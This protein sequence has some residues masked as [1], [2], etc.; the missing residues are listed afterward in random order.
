MN[1]YKKNSILKSENL[2]IGYILKKRNIEIAKGLNISLKLGKLVCLLGKNGTGK[3]TLLRTIAKIQ[4]PIKG[5]LFIKDKNINQYSNL[6]LAK[7]ISLV[8]TERIPENNLTVFELV[9]LGRQPYTN[10]IGNLNTTD[11]AKINEA[12][13][14]TDIKNL[15]DN[16]FNELSD[17]QKQRVLIARAIAQDTPIIIL[18][19]PTAHLDI[20]HKIATVRLLKTISQ[21]MNKSI[22]MAT[23]EVQL[24]LSLADELWLM[25]NNEFNIGSPDDLITNG[26]L[27]SLFSSKY[28]EF[29]LSSRQFII[30]N[31]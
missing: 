9:A 8:L 20:H 6:E 23:H 21:K 5:T 10:W 18:D 29:D 13:K 14:Q 4:N 7:I 30:T 27:N 22:I 28:I 15:K 12:L 11:Y 25:N 1:K 17:G 26:K 31:K 16:K 24:A 2:T 19:E 3:S